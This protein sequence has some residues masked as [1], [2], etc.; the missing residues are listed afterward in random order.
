MQRSAFDSTMAASFSLQLD[1]Y[2]SKHWLQ[3][4]V[5]H[6]EKISGGRGEFGYG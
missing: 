6:V 3:G 5:V 2:K 1:A 4:F